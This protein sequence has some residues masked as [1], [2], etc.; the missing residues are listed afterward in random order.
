MFKALL[1]SPEKTS[2]TLLAKENLENGL[3]S[4]VWIVCLLNG[5]ITLSNS[6]SLIFINLILFDVG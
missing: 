2:S 1:N 6:C 4:S 3:Y 5:K